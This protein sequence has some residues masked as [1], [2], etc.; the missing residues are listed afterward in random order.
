MKACRIAD[1]RMIEVDGRCFLFLPAQNAI[2]EVEEGIRSLI[3]IYSRSRNRLNADVLQLKEYP[4]AEPLR[5]LIGLR[6]VVPEENDPVPPWSPSA[7]IPMQTLVLHLTDSCNLDCVYC[8]HGAKEDFSGKCAVMDHKT[9]VRGVDLL[10]EKSGD[11]DAVTLV[12]FGGEPLL[13]FREIKKIAAYARKKASEYHKKLRLALTT[14]G[15]LLTEEI[16]QF[17]RDEEISVTVSIDGPADIQDRYRPFPGGKPSFTAVSGGVERLIRNRG[18]Q[19]IAARVTVA[20]SPAHVTS[21]LDYLLEMGF[22]EVGFS[23]VT[24]LEAGYQLDEEA[25]NGLL[26]QFQQ[27]SERFLTA[28]QYG[29]LLGFTNLI[30]LLVNLHEGQVKTHP[31]GAGLGM[32]SVG[33]DGRLYLCQRLTGSGRFAMGNVYDGIDNNRVIP[34][35]EKSSLENRTGCHPC[36]AR[37]I[38]AG[39]CYHEALI[40]QGSLTTPNRHYCRWIRKWLDIGLYTYARLCLEN[41]DYLDKL[42]LLRGHAPFQPK[43]FMH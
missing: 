10:M 38:C 31:C 27:L 21:T 32:F 7:E 22:S 28:A 41:I 37:S 26:G 30:D 36:P 17:I 3:D 35:R 1:H 14:N 34:F 8:Y 33:V 12:L 40:R 19:P 6:V 43:A 42:S 4:P 18:Q 2:F 15:V 16:V 24:T 29:D 20:R 13:C 9:A 25:M 5:S 23:P 39:G 11:Q